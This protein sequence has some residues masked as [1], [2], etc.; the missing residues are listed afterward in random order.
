[1][2]YF[3]RLGII[4]LSLSFCLFLSAQEMTLIAESFDYDVGFEL[5][6]QGAAEGG[7]D[8]NWEYSGDTGTI[9]VYPGTIL[10]DIT[11]QRFGNYIELTAESG[12]FAAYR[13]LNPPI[14]DDGQTFWI[15]LLYQ[16]I[17]GDYDEPEGDPQQSYNGFSLYLEN[18]ELLYIGKP[19]GF[20]QLGVAAHGSTGDEVAID[21]EATDG[22]WMV[23]K[24]SMNGTT[25]DDS[26]Y[27]FLNPDPNTEPDS[28]ESDFRFTWR[29]SNGVDRVRLGCNYVC[30][31]AFDEIKIAPTYADL[32][33]APSGIFTSPVG[34]LPYKFHLEQNYPNPFNPSTTISYNVPTQTNVRIA[35]YDILGKEVTTL[36]DAVKMPGTYQVSFDASQL[37]SG[38]YF[39]QMQAGPYSQTRKMML[40]E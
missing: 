18:D 9:I 34:N 36:V 1:M 26:C 13:Y 5:D 6:G 3:Y 16:R 23:F 19:W 11:A 33:T 14:S 27:A 20:S 7:W 30:W 37:T 25:D 4:L 28:T 31:A 32:N 40:L 29:G 8:G 39:Y 17:P 10:E 22:G 38:I 12:D 24:F 21:Y 2:K 35:V 15:S